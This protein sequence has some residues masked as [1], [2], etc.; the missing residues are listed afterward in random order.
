MNTCTWMVSPW[1]VL[2]FIVVILPRD[3]AFQPP[4][5]PRLKATHEFLLRLQHLHSH[6]SE[7]EDLSAPDTS[8]DGPHQPPSLS[9]WRYSLESLEWQRPH[10]TP[11]AAHHTWS[12]CKN[13]VLPLQ[14]C[15]WARASVETPQ[16]LQ[17]FLADSTPNDEIILNVG[18]RFRDFLKEY[19]HL[20]SAAIF[21]IVFPACDFGDYYNWFD[22][23][24][25]EWELMDD[26][27]VAPFHPDWVFA[28][29]PESL[30]FEKRSP[31]PTVTLVSTRVVDKA[32]EEATKQIGLQNEKT[33]LSKSPAELRQMWETCLQSGADEFE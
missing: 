12:W 27:I 31:Y 24:E 28:G 30:Q 15:P 29:E 14:L 5:Q 4:Y 22:E 23:M 17:L 32:G 10:V 2:V 16:A 8:D 25:A 9:V 13:F 33:L 3:F 11:V 1:T 6:S 18:C 7:Q 21:F 26:V 19:P 20:E